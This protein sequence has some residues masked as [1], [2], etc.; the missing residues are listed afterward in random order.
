MIVQ[1]GI[2]SAQQ[3]NTP[4]YLIS[5]HQTKG[6]IDSANKNKINA[7]FDRLNLRKNY[8]EIDSIRYPRDSLLKNY[9]ENDYI[10]HFKKIISFF[11][12]YIGE[13]LLNRFK[14]YPD[15]ETK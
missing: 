2:G 4:K 5:A 12:E 8:G 1:H 9:Q 10:E 11:K 15:M 6:R 13:P 7:I 3:V 14:S